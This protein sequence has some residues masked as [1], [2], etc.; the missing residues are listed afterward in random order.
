MNFDNLISFTQQEQS[1]PSQNTYSSINNQFQFAPSITPAHSN[2]FFAHT[3]NTNE[4]T[5]HNLFPMNNQYSHHNAH[6]LPSHQPPHV[7]M[8]I[9]MN[10]YPKVMNINMPGSQVPASNDYLLNAKPETAKP[11]NLNIN[12]GGVTFGQES[13]ETQQQGT[14]WVD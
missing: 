11:V 9:N 7:T 14:S 1:K 2:Y 8:N 5:P 3:Q 6:S 4:H 10:M 13:K 12:L